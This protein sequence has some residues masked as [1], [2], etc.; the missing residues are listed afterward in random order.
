VHKHTCGQREASVYYQA[1]VSVA[2][3]T[4]TAMDA[5]VALEWRR[6]HLRKTP[7]SAGAR[8]R[9]NRARTPAGDS[10]HMWRYRLAGN[11]AATQRFGGVRQRRRYAFPGGGRHGFCAT[12]P[13][14]RGSSSFRPS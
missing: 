10:F 1:R 7:R 3:S 14:T 11:G 9:F 13:F 4:G 12:S 8:Q 6:G 5:A 2:Q